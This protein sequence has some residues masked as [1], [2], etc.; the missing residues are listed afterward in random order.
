MRTVLYM[1][2]GFVLGAVA[3]LGLALATVT[4]GQIPSQSGGRETHIVFVW[5]PA[6]AILGLIAGLI[7][8]FRR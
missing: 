4:L 2:A 6:G 3:V 8:W 1:S 5:M 7:L